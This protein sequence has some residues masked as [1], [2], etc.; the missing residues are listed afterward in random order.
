MLLSAFI[1]I[2]YVFFGPSVIE[3]CYIEFVKM[4]HS[5]MS[6]VLPN[7]ALPFDRATQLIPTQ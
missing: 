1:D 6:K 2:S 7:I 5:T 3:Q 4:D